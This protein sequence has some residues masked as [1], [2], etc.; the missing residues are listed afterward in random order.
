MVAWLCQG[1]GLCLASDPPLEVGTAK[2]WV[3]TV[4]RDGA[5]GF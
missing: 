5:L 3:K 1:P 2:S 4:L